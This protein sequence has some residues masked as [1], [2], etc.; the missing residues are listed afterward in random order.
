[1]DFYLLY[2]TIPFYVLIKH[3][4]AEGKKFMRD[5]FA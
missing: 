1:M 2:K 5:F 3:K 4:H